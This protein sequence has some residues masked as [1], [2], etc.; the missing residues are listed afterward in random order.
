MAGLGLTSGCP[1]GSGR[2]LSLPV[3][4]GGHGATCRHMAGGGHRSPSS[5][6]GS[7]ERRQ[8]VEGP[9]GPQ[10]HPS[11]RHLLPARQQLPGPSLP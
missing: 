8:E 7:G 9:R 4:G 2:R 3:A 1:P 5:R 10:D 11:L 6:Q